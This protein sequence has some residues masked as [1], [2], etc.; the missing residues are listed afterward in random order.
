MCRVLLITGTRKGIGR[1]LAAYYVKKG[2][3]VVGCSRGPASVE[4]N[5]YTHYQVDVADE[6]AV[7]RMV[8]D[9][10]KK[11]GRLDVLIN[12]AGI[13]AMNHI[14]LTPLQTV[15]DIFRT[16]VLG[17]FLVMRE[18]GKVM[19]KQ[20][21]GRIVNFT[22]VATALRLEGEAVKPPLKT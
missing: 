3:I 12:N 14:F 22:T 4:E 11:Q 6:K 10:K 20:G 8:R 1:E 18:A 15:Q 19:V 16:N 17:S 5:N 9:I 2:N 13:A 7:I 21:G